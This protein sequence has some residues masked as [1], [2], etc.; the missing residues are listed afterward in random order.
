MTT[1]TL[2]TTIATDPI[3]AAFERGV[4]MRAGTLAAARTAATHAAAAL[5]RLAAA[6]G[7]YRVTALRR[8]ADIVC[9][10]AQVLGRLA[11]GVDHVGVSCFA[12]DH[13]AVTLGEASA[14]LQTAATLLR[15]IAETI[16]PGLSTTGPHARELFL[17]ASSGRGFRPGTEPVVDV[18]I[19]LENAAADIDEVLERIEGRE[20]LPHVPYADIAAHIGA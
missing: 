7:P 6:A 19:A 11:R 15:N 13:D 14:E 17:A 1:M 16:R 20:F 2:T 12:R 9:D 18:A 10:Q 4:D 8:I 3:D 5:A